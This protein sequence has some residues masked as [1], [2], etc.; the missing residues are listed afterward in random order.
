[1]IKTVISFH[2]RSCCSVLL[3]PLQLVNDVL[4]A[5]VS[6]AARRFPNVPHFWFLVLLQAASAGPRPL[7]LAPT[8]YILLKLQHTMDVFWTLPPVS[9]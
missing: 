2:V 3:P 5:Y 9:R 8:L 7:H 1:M 4:Y 6:C